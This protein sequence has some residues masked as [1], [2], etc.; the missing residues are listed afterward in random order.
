[1][2]AASPA[3]E[4]V[5]PAGVRGEGSLLVLVVDVVAD[6]HATHARADVGGITAGRRPNCIDC[7]NPRQGVVSFRTHD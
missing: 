3:I 1:V 2:A 7:T 5:L 6:R 4:A